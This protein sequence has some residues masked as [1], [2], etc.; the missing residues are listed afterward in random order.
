MG[1]SRRIVLLFAVPLVATAFDTAHQRRF[2]GLAGQALVADVIDEALDLLQLGTQHLGVVEVVIPAPFI[3]EDLENHR[4]HDRISLLERCDVIDLD[5]KVPR[6]A[7]R[8]R[9]KTGIAHLVSTV[10]P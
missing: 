7:P 1:R 5:V 3:R 10:P 9:K 2:G 8:S 6:N 4:K